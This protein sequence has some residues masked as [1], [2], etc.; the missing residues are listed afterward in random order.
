MNLPNSNKQG[1]SWAPIRPSGRAAFCDS[2]L[3]SPA[4]VSLS[5]ASEE[6]MTGLGLVLLE[7]W[8]MEKVPS[9]RE[10]GALLL[11]AG[12]VVPGGDDID[13][14][15]RA[16]DVL[17]GIAGVCQRHGAIFIGTVGDS[18][19]HGMIILDQAALSRARSIEIGQAEMEQRGRMV[20]WDVL[21]M[22]GDTAGGGEMRE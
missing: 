10:G 3:R 1:E 4:G 11:K 12:V 20:L 21:R 7:G 19:S 6:R 13:V 5:G 8:S 22:A 17:A 14:I 9:E 2:S 18:R 16:V 15:T